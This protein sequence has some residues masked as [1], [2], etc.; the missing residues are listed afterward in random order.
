MRSLLIVTGKHQQC[1]GTLMV[2]IGTCSTYVCMASN[3]THNNVFCASQTFYML[4]I[5]EECNCYF[6]IIPALP[7]YLLNCKFSVLV[8]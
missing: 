2:H 7:L 3:S 4:L 5:S 1:Y 8:F 6:K